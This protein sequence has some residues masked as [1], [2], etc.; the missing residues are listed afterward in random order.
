LN[1]KNDIPVINGHPIFNWHLEVSSK[2]TLH[3]PRC[4]RTER[5][6]MYKIT[7]HSLEF[8]QKI[9]TPEILSRTARVLLCGGQGD[10]IYCHDFLDIV[11]YIKKENPNVCVHIITNG[12]YKTTT[13]WIDL[14]QLL[15]HNDIVTFSIDG[16]DNDSNN[17]YR[18]N[19]NYDSAVAGLKTLRKYNSKV[20]II[21][22][23]IVFK[24]NQ[25]KLDV[26]C[27]Q[28]R[29]LDV[30]Y[31][32]IVESFLFGSNIP[33]YINKELG[34]DP[35]EPNKVSDWNYHE[36]E[37][38][39]LTDRVYPERNKQLISQQAQPVIEEYQQ[40]SVI[41]LCRTGERA[42]YVDAEGILYPCSWISHPFRVRRS[43]FKDKEITWDQSL[44]VKY[45]DR[46]DLKQH[47]LEQILLGPDWQK[48][49]ASWRDPA[50]S[51]VECDNK[52]HSK[53][54]VNRINNKLNL[55][56]VDYET[57][58]KIYREK[59]GGDGKI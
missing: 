54:T 18:V 53:S 36:L 9:L 6:G 38:V 40:G 7:E 32:N 17:L 8:V 16:W 29:E 51:F 55:N 33:N 57:F 26:I 37:V 22:S 59:F 2:C 46:F 30:D 43:K 39:K 4:P 45:K 56:L 19:S 13:W 41:P 35:L 31:F 27:D 11:A 49:T 44:F 25:D 10:P 23:T 20:F 28:A 52:C 34:Y 47:S 48:I 58:V 5:K 21:W 24:F 1:Q 12:S 14:A 50:K 3:C 15:N 42:I